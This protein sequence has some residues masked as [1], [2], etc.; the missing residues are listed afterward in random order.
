MESHE[1]EAPCM[2]PKYVIK[3]VIEELLEK[4][5]FMEDL[6]QRYLR[7]QEEVEAPKLT[8]LKDLKEFNNSINDK[9]VELRRLL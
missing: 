8:R 4:R 1:G 5:D 9:N 2:G 6:Y 3:Y 7:A